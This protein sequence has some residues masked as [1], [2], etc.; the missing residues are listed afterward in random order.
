[1][2]CGSCGS[3]N[4]EGFRFC[5]SCGTALSDRPCPS[6]GFAAPA[7]TRF[8]GRCGTAL[9]AGPATTSTDVP[10]LV[11]GPLQDE[12]KLAT[13]LFADVVGFTSL[14]EGTDPETV[15]RTV[16]AAFRR[17]SQ[18]VDEHGGTVDKY[19]G[20]CLMAVFGV[21][22]AHADDAERAVAA[23]LAMRTLG[24]D[25][26]FS[27]GVNTGEVMVTSVG[28][29]GEVTV[30][31]DTVNVAARLEK[32]AGA[33]QVLVGRLTAE[34]A[35]DRVAFEERQ[36]VLL[37]GKADPVDVFEA[38]ALRPEIDGF[39]GAGT[40]DRPPLTGRHDELAFLRA[41]W[42][43]SVRD[44][45]STVVLLAGEAG[46]GTT[47]LIE[48]LALDPW[49]PEGKL[50]GAGQPIVVR[51]TYPAYGGLGG[52]RVAADI[53]RQLGPTGDPHIDARVRSLA[54]ELHPSLKSIDPAALQSEQLWAF[55][56]L[57][58]MKTDEGP[59]LL[60]V[61][62]IHRATDR[63]IDLL[64][65]L[66]VRVVDVP[67]V[68]ILAGR[69]DPPAWLASFP[70]AT[71]M[72]LNPL[73]AT[74]AVELANALACE[75]RLTESAAA[76]LAG[77][78]GGNPLHLRELIGML[79]A[80]G[81]LI[82]TP[83][84]FEL[85]GNV[86]LPPSLHAIL[87]ARLDAL[88]PEE[89]LGLQHVAVL[90]DAATSAQVEALGQPDAMRVLQSLVSAGLLHQGGD[91]CYDVADPLM[92]EV[93]YE[94]LPRNVRADRHRRAARVAPSDFERARHLERATGYA[95]DDDE[96]AAE[97][98]DALTSAGR[99]LLDNS[100][101][102]DGLLLLQRAIELG[103]TD[104]ALLLRV[105]QSYAEM[106]RTAE[107]EAVF[108]VLLSGGP[109]PELQAHAA[110]MHGLS[111]L[112]PAPA[113]AR[114]PLTDAA[115]AWATLGNVE[116]EGWARANLGVAEFMSGNGPAA[117]ATLENA[118]ERFASIGNRTG[119]LAC[120]R[121]LSLV[122]PEDPRVPAWLAEALREAEVAGDRT[123][124]VTTLNTL[125]W[126]EFLRIR[127]GGPEDTVEAF[128]YCRRLA[129]LSKEI[130]AHDLQVYGDLLLADMARLQGDLDTARQALAAAATGEDDSERGRALFAAVEY[131]VARAGGDDRAPPDLPMDVHDPVILSAVFIVAEERGMAGDVGAAAELMNA[132]G[133]R[134]GLE[135]LVALVGGMLK[136]LTSLVTGDFDEARG[137]AER[138]LA[139]ARLLDARPAVAAAQGTLAEIAIRS[140]PA[141][142]RAEAEARLDGLDVPSAGV[143]RALALRPRA[144]LGDAA[145]RS[146]LAAIVERL[147]APG[148]GLGV[149]GD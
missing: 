112:F 25:I 146:E 40:R 60:A 94:T 79:K 20:D 5:G 81:E 128:D 64:R 80:R 105:A 1:V 43:R 141:A 65:E 62:D 145:A 110:H 77:R 42:R 120:Y 97:A 27:I 68:L 23:G 57:L 86:S 91:G 102:L 113:E 143:A 18:V 129:H 12:R 126:N 21:P 147:A 138:A 123:A 30:I 71:V 111:L 139:S 136:A 53:I 34:L 101:V 133:A 33:G 109:D 10:S 6:C 41:Q 84:G 148:L 122:R 108:R 89:K 135:M 51:A 16:D 32:A 93:A 106:G 39:E 99:D 9:T 67:L 107:T 121:F 28:R 92:R 31:G 14:A 63:T 35:G 22:Q 17:M 144:L 119:E 59:I 50:P 7:G 115:N 8:C 70:S 46:L 56:R 58:E 24:G 29:D 48:E 96:L 61:D 73:G 149:L 37:K 100:R 125:A 38:T 78:A 127:L 2:Q 26:A 55:R 69:P 4:P 74:D 45:R 132:I 116:K 44:R 137:H 88:A 118:L 49:G 47:R 15:A 76:V 85:A 140:D 117:A 103:L 75:S 87:A 98:R 54:G 95:P 3:D 134:P 124:Q 72:R 104:R 83:A 130:G 114:Q 90:G 19:L 36:P 11:R 13:V 131:A 52:P 142:G 66:A 82:E